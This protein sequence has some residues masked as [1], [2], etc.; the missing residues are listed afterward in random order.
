[1][2]N[3]KKLSESQKIHQNKIFKDN[4]KAKKGEKLLKLAL[5]IFMKKFKEKYCN[6]SINLNYKKELSQAFIV[7]ET[8]KYF[9]SN[10]SYIENKKS[11]IEPDGGTFFYDLDTQKNMTI[12]SGLLFASEY[13]KQGDGK[14]QSM[15]NA[16]ERAHK[17]FNE[18]VLASLNMPYCLYFI[19]CSG[20]DFKTGS[21]IKDRLTAITLKRP[22]NK[23]YYEKLKG[24]CSA[25]VYV[26]EN[27]WTTK[28]MSDIIFDGV[29]KVIDSYLIKD[30]F[31]EGFKF[32]EFN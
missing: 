3:D 23:T 20:T 9:G 18:Y 12:N 26:K 1:M 27:S 17:N 11:H 24:H 7:N 14:D 13:K 32:D 6:V 19:F 2:S 8:Q 31:N 10:H 30:K 15:G 29:C 5:K 28:E 25:S 4:E 21:S 22:F 16:I